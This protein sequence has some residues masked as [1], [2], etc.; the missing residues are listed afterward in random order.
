V[1]TYSYFNTKGGSVWGGSPI[2][3]SWT[4][5]GFCCPCFFLYVWFLCCS[6]VCRVSA[7]LGDV[8]LIYV[9]ETA[10]NPPYGLEP[11]TA[12]REMGCHSVISYFL[13]RGCKEGRQHPWGC[14]RV[15]GSIGE[16]ARPSIV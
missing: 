13:L 12:V 7:F 4:Q 10:T 1:A 2:G 15:C 9:I 11:L 16:T 14:L 8:S 6:L 5:E 3:P